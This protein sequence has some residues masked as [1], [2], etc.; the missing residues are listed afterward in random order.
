MI[1]T[2]FLLRWMRD[3]PALETRAMDQSSERVQAIVRQHLDAVCRTARRLGVPAHDLDDVVQD[4][5][6]VVVRRLR[7]IEAGKERAYAVS[8]C[9]RV[10]ANWR[11]RRRPERIDTPLDVI[12]AEALDPALRRSSAPADEIVDRSRQLALLET[13]LQQ[14]TDVQRE[15]F[16]LFELEE[17]TARQVSETLGVSEGT[18]V[19][20]VRRAREVLW[21]VCESAGH[22]AGEAAR[23]ARVEPDE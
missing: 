16:V 14:M 18:V 20:R 3:W 15:A 11:R 17:L 7:D 4:V 6:L 1:L 9:V 10:V 23:R 13:A 21:G 8:I 22:P 19:S 12:A 5:M 2:M